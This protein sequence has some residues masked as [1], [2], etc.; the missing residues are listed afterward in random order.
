MTSLH[1]QKS[2]FGGHPSTQSCPAN[3]CLPDIPSMY[4]ADSILVKPKSS[5]VI[6]SL[7]VRVV[8]TYISRFTSLTRERGT[9][10]ES[11]AKWKIM[12]KIR[13]GAAW[14]NAYV[15][16]AQNLGYITYNCG[17][18]CAG[19]HANENVRIWMKCIAFYTTGY[20]FYTRVMGQLLYKLYHCHCNYRHMAMNSRG[21]QD[22]S[23][24]KTL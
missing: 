3:D 19:Q 24:C 22:Y 14:R 13:P 6:H 23:F 7:L 12:C 16:G 15:L 2:V 21:H 17:G 9:C 18:S 5:S 11:V 1:S 20:A 8:T 10:S 4:I